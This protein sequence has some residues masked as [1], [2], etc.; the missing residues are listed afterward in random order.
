MEL[1]TAVRTMA[2]AMCHDTGNDN[3]EKKMSAG[4]ARRA[5]R[6]GRYRLS[7]YYPS[8][9]VL[10]CVPGCAAH[11]GVCCAECVCSI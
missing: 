1:C 4:R 7:A 3:M 9:D 6:A 10:L 2:R 5:H 11:C 8:V